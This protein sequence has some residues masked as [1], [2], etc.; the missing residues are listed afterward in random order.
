MEEG[1][2]ICDIELY[3]PVPDLQLLST[4]RSR[5]CIYVYSEWASQRIPDDQVSCIDVSMLPYHLFLEL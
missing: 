2:S 1:A 4:A 5:C 3:P